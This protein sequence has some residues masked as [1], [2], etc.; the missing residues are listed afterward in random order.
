MHGRESVVPQTLNP[1]HLDLGSSSQSPQSVAASSAYFLHKQTLDVYTY[2]PIQDFKFAA[3][4]LPFALHA[5]ERR[6]AEWKMIQ[7]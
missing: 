3:L 2:W 1:E 4:H 5:D 7:I 6:G